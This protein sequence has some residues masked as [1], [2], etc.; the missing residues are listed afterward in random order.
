MQF[1]FIGIL[2]FAF[3]L[4]SFSLFKISLIRQTYHLPYYIKFSRHVNFAILRCEYFATLKFRDLISRFLVRHNL[5]FL[6]NIK[7]TLELNKTISSKEQNVKFSKNVRAGLNLGSSNNR[8]VLTMSTSKS[9][10]YVSYCP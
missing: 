6:G 9:C 7:H 3:R 1:G 2:S 8:A 10:L 4:S 5:H